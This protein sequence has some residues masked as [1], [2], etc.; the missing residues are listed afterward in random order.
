[1][2]QWRH[3]GCRL[4]GEREVDADLVRE[5]VREELERIRAEIDD[6]EWFQRHGRPDDTTEIFEEVALGADFVDF[7]TLVAYQR[8]P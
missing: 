4:D 3:H 1:V 8:L 2:W 6:D 7:L 5:I